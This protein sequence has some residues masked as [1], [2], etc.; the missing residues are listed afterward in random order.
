MRCA[1][2]N[3]DVGG[4]LGVERQLW[5][6]FVEGLELL[7]CCLVLVGS[8]QLLLVQELVVGLDPLR[9]SLM[10]LWPVVRNAS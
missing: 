2:L 3:R 1:G 4:F 8:A 7:K 10:S 6:P 5:I 9:L